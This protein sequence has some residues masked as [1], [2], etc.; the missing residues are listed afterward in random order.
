MLISNDVVAKV[1][2][3]H[4]GLTNS[5][6]RVAVIVATSYVVG[7]INAGVQFWT[8][9]MIAVGNSENTDGSIST[10]VELLLPPNASIDL[11][12]RK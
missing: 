2:M 8:E 1:R 10:F 6:D 5:G 11:I 7:K 3:E 9:K 12:P 4:A